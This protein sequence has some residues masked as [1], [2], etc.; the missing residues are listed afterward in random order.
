V[1]VNNIHILVD[2]RA[3]LI[4]APPPVQASIE[5]EEDDDYALWQ[6]SEEGSGRTEEEVEFIQID[7]WEEIV[8]VSSHLNSMEGVNE[9][10]TSFIVMA[11]LVNEYDGL[12]HAYTRWNGK[13][14]FI[15]S[16]PANGDAYLSP[17]LSPVPMEEE[18]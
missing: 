8:G 5:D 12:L 13:S 16:F 2:E 9:A 3:W 17:P 7:I 1:Q 10:K 15:Q 14:A 6:P 4:N 11:N 18:Q